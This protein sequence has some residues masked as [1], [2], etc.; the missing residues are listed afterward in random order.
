MPMSIIKTLALITKRPTLNLSL[1]RQCFRLVPFNPSRNK[2]NCHHF[3]MSG[4]VQQTRPL[5]DRRGTKRK[6]AEV[7]VPEALPPKAATVAKNSTPSIPT[8]TEATNVVSILD[9]ADIKAIINEKVHPPLVEGN[10]IAVPTDTIYGVACLAQS[11]NAIKK[12]YDI[13]H[14]DVQ[15][16]IA[17]CVAEIDDIAKYAEVVIPQALL[18]ALLPGP[19]TLVLK[20]K[21]KLNPKLNPTTDLVGVRIPDN[22]FIRELAR[23][24][25]TPLALTSANISADPSCT[26]IEEFKH[27]WKELAVVVDGGD[28]ISKSKAGSTVVDLSVRGEYT[29]IRPGQAHKQTI[30][31]LELHGLQPRKS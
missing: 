30:A 4:G 24:C 23:A 31:L 16:P 26:K 27:I 29:I 12:I 22:V 3:E 6:A 15:K 1:A 11:T 20:R 10:V 7:T 18:E 13:K 21:P 9:D 5:S 19:V 2:V 25:K 28:L 17:I 14:R 8:Q